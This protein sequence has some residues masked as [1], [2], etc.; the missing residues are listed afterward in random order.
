M[1]SLKGPRSQIIGFGPKYY[2]IN[3]IGDLQ[4]CYLGVWTLGTGCLGCRGHGLVLGVSA[5]MVWGLDFKSYNGLA[6]SL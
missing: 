2:N 1:D 4:S 6:Q 5:S 3:G